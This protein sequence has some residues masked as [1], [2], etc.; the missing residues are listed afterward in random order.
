MAA[1]TI[2]QRCRS[3]FFDQCFSTNWT[4]EIW[5]FTDKMATITS[6]YEKN[7]KQLLAFSRNR[8]CHTHE[9]NWEYRQ[10]LTLLCSAVSNNIMKILNF[11]QFYSFFP[12]KRQKNRWVVV[13]FLKHSCSALKIQIPN[14]NV[15][16]IKLFSAW[17]YKNLHLKTL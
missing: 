5:D 8:T 13:T 12:C 10:L 16:L 14:S 6:V 2:S 1:Q 4:P 3:V 11:T 17:K 7:K 15:F 9:P